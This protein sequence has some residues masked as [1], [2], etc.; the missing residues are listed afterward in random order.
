MAS[1]KDLPAGKNAPDEV[2]VVIEIPQESNIK[3][4][5][6]EETGA[7]FVDRFLHTAMNYP[8]NYGFI[9]STKADDG[10]PVDVLVISKFPVAPGTVIIAQP[11]GML[12]MEDEAGQDEKI[13][14]VPR[15]KVDPEYGALSDIS[16]LPES[17]KNKIKH[18]F[19]HYKDL[20]EGKWVKVREWESK[21]KA[22]EVITKSLT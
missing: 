13:V 9:P 21:E 10:D 1:L 7:M 17:I 19:E 11:I 15:K 18:F 5:I 14:A 2:N 12:N 22:L 8:F 6:D 3:Y 20:E 16:E 4:E